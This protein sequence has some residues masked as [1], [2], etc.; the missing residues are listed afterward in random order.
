MTPAEVAGVLGLLSGS[1]PAFRVIPDVIEAWTL[2]LEPYDVRDVRAAVVML[3]RGLDD[4]SDVGFP[5]T[6]ASVCR[7]A[8]IRCRERNEREEDERRR[9][10]TVLDTMTSEERAQLAAKGRALRDRIA[11]GEALASVLG[12]VGMPIASAPASDAEMNRKRNEALTAI[13][14]A[15]REERIAQRRE[16]IRLLTKPRGEDSQSH[17]TS[18]AY[19]ER[20]APRTCGPRAR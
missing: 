8:R 12:A 7:L 1:F 5:P 4:E 9:T 11:A 20:T 18:A 19:R 10:V 15:A 3:C 16:Q 2:V 6:S 14:A 13:E 17:T